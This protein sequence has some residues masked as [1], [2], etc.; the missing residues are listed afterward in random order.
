MGYFDAII[1]G[2]VQGLT[3]FLP[4]SSSGHLVILQYFMGLREAT[5]NVTFDLFLH[6]AT[7]LAVMWV[8]RKDLVSIFTSVTVG[9]NNGNYEP[10][11]KWR[12]VG[13]LAISIIVTGIALPFKDNLETLFESIEGVRI[14]LLVNAVALAVLPLLRKSGKG[15][16]K[17]TWVGAVVIGLA[18]ACGVLPGISRSGSTIIAGL[19][20]GLAPRE[21]CRYSF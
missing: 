20:L 8:Y 9:G 18:Q 10:I 7:L 13:F 11:P 6:L 3:E 5:E 12:L 19:A 21:A 17:L 4:V 1:L 14:F 2:I 15:P 16:G